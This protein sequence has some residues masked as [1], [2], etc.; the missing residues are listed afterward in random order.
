M[1]KGEREPPRFRAMRKTKEAE[2]RWLE[3]LRKTLMRKCGGQRVER[4]REEPITG[5]RRSLRRQP[6]C[7]KGVWHKTLKYCII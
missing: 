5:V 2:G 4:G 1:D 6:T 3:T 7:L